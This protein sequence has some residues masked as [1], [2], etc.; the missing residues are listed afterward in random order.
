MR[1]VFAS[2]DVDP[3]ACHLRE[4]RR[5]REVEDVHIVVHL[6]AIEAAKDEEP[7]IGEERD[8]VP[9]RRWRFPCG[10]TRLEIER[11]YA[12]TRS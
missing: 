4:I 6:A 8:V 11:D 1:F 3:E 5:T 12:W 9:A 10:R 7:A 2:L